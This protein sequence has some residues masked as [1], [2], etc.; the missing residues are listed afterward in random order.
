MTTIAQPHLFSWHEIEASPE[1]LRLARVLDTLPDEPIMRAL[2][3]QRRGKRNDYPIEAVWN[4]LIAGIVFG[5]DSVQSLRRELLRNAELRQVCGFD[6]MRREKA[7]PSAPV[8]SRFLAKLYK[9]QPLIDAMFDKLVEEVAALLPDFGKDL[10]IDGKAVQTH[11]L[12]DPEAQWS[13]KKTYLTTGAN[14]KTD[15]HAKWWFG[16]KLHLIIDANYELPVGFEVSGA[17][18]SETTR[19]LPMIEEVERKHPDLLARTRS[20]LGDKGYD[21]GGDK[22]KLYDRYGIIPLIDTR[23]LHTNGGNDGKAPRPRWM[24]LDPLH[25]DAIYYD[26]TGRVACRVAP[27]EADDEKAFARMEFKGFEK[28]RQTLKFRCPA[29]AYGIECHNRDAC[30]CKLATREG[31]HGRVVRVPLDRDRRLFLPTHR[32]SATFRQAYKKRSAVER[33]NSRIDQV[34]GFERHFIRGL[35]KMRLRMGL[36]M[37]VMLA[38]AVAWIRA[39]EQEKVR[40][41]LRAA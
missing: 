26:G 1:I 15:K 35:G 24:P 23:N 12:K 4:S 11:G 9:L 6:P 2:V 40:S 32:H 3:A 8:Y 29:A 25:H 41:L 21:D 22:A 34:Y 38:T 17:A 39:G 18:V 20:L 37:A 10:A 14:G 30:R 5:H 31:K 13:A 19:L 16:Y 7:V 36:T 28:D 27:F 33:V